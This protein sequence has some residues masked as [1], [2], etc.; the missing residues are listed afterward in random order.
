MR[1]ICIAFGLAI[2]GAAAH[3]TIEHTGGYQSPHAVLTIAI[4]AGV[5]IGSLTLGAAWRS[6]RY[7][8]VLA[9]AVAL[10]CGELFGLVRT[11]ERLIA[12]REAAQ[13]PHRDAART[14]QDATQE[15]AQL[16][17]A[18]GAMPT[19]SPRLTAATKAKQQADAAVVAQASLRG[20]RKNC[21]QLL[22]DQV[23]R[24]AAEIEAARAEVTRRHQFAAL[25]ATKA[26]RALAALPPGRSGTPLAD[27]LGVAPWVVDL[28]TAALGAIGANG[29]A[30]C[31]I[32]FGAHAAPRR[33]DNIDC[34]DAVT[35]KAVPAKRSKPKLIA[36]NDRPIYGPAD[37]IADMLDPAP[38]VRTEFEEILIAYKTACDRRGMR[39]VGGDA[40]FETLGELCTEVGIQSETMGDHIYLLDV[41][42]APPKQEIARRN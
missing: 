3:V 36:A 41:K 35:V 6:G 25:A 7:V 38:G 15:A 42:I 18:L 30:A 39:S 33:V 10:L 14:R 11:A 24:A 37:F 28:V 34:V 19:T 23:D 1:F 2:L 5:G 22:Q 17:A 21:R 31:L 29:L 9:T 40:F 16:R 13:A 12:A 27:R 26:Q 32:V 4:A 8:L 20:C